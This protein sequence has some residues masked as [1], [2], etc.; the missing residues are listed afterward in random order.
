MKRKGV[1]AEKR[2]WQG[3]WVS[4]ERRRQ[5]TERGPGIWMLTSCGGARACPPGRG[6]LPLP[7]RLA[8]LPEQESCHPGSSLMRHKP[9]VHVTVPAPAWWW[10]SVFL[11]RP[12]PHVCYS[13]PESRVWIW[14]HGWTPE[15][16]PGTVL[17]RRRCPWLS[18][19][20][21]PLR[22]PVAGGHLSPPPCKPPVPR[23]RTPRPPLTQPCEWVSCLFAG[24]LGRHRSVPQPGWQVGVST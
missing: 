15:P 2:D 10:G 7:P 14:G 23:L 20:P 17:T 12:V 24:R 18:V 11:P 8:T 22:P 16:G 3:F 19:A 1:Q 6:W 13:L 4:P 5:V 21:W 9:A